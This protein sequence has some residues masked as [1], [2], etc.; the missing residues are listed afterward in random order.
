MIIIIKIM[1]F[2]YEKI[3]ILIIIKIRFSRNPLDIFEIKR[4]SIILIIMKMRA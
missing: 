1:I 3:K 2:K 4:A